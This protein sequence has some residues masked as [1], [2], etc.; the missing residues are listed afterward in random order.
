MFADFPAAF[1][2]ALK[3]LTTIPFSGGATIAAQ[4]FISAPTITE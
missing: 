3:I 4:R 2:P 1:Q